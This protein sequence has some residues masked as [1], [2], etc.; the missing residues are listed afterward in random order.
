M[1]KLLALAVVPAALV[2]LSACST[3]GYDSYGYGSY[4]YSGSDY[5]NYGY[6][7]YSPSY[8]YGASYGGDIWYDAYYDDFYGPVYGGYWAPDGYFWYQNRLGGIRA[9]AVEIESVDLQPALGMIEIRHRLFD[10]GPESRAVVHFLQVRHF[11]GGDVV[12]NG[13]RCQHQPP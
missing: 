2:G 1:K 4:G 10:K 8:G 12:E 6:S 13:G 7:S 11:V 3:Y 9:V 5:G